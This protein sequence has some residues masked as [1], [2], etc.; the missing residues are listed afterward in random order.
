[1][2]ERKKKEKEEKR[3]LAWKSWFDT[4]DFYGE[5]EISTRCS[6]FDRVGTCR[7][8]IAPPVHI[9]IRVF[10]VSSISISRRPITEL[11][12]VRLINLNTGGEAEARSHRIGG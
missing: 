3:N 8:F 12:Y 11:D 1:M 6:Q 10:S 7:V 9:F 2:I 4:H 5:R